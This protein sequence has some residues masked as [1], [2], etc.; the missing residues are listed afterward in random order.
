[1]LYCAEL[2]R[3]HLYTNWEGGLGGDDR[4]MK[5]LT[6][7]YAIME[8]D[9]D[10]TPNMRLSH[11]DRSKGVGSPMVDSLTKWATAKNVVWVGWKNLINLGKARG[12]AERRPNLMKLSQKARD[13]VTRIF[14]E[15][16]K[17][18]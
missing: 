3:G 1:L 17:K 18:S 12:N 7:N 14:F 5:P 16:M 15:R 11:F 6:E 4:P 9:G 13:A 8:K 2:V 10:R